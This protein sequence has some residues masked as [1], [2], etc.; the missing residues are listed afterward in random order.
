[1]DINDQLQ[2]IVASIID[3]LKGTI[4]AELRDQISDE[5]VKKLATEEF[6]ATVDAQVR[7]HIQ[8]RLDNFNFIK[9][10]DDNLQQIVANL[11]EQINRNLAEAANRQITDFITNKL[12]QFDVTAVLTAL[13]DSKVGNLLTYQH[14][15]DASIP[16]ASIDFSGFKLT[17]DQVSGG[18]ITNFGS[19]GIEDRATHVQLTLLD[20]ASAFEGPLFSPAIT[21]KGDITVDGKLIINGTV[22]A[23]ASGFADLVNKTSLATKAQLND[24]LFASFSDII[25]NKIQTDGIDLDKITQ[26]GKEIVAGNKLGY[27]ITDTNIRRLG[28]VN[29][30]QTSGENLL[31]ETLY[32]TKGRVGVNTMD[33]TAALSI[34]DQ[35]VE[36]TV[37]KHT[38]DIGYVGTP[39][40]QKLILGSN[41]K[42]NI[43]LDIDGS[44][45]IDSLR[46]GNVPMTSSVTVPNYTG[47]R[48]QL[49]WNEIP[50]P[51]A[52]IGWVCLGGTLWSGFG[53]I[54]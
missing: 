42:K 13:V 24:E 14:F 4:E 28:V 7:N 48:G 53:T 17:G 8:A 29:D 43:V 33:P 50:A 1:M 18:I 45:V 20:H 44:V 9:A 54:S 38:Q 25:F 41:S 30:L 34:W 47:D 31:S 21:V 39:R 5:V 23:T 46:I 11:S 10:S 51:G 12:K 22:D 36:V 16:H 26:G 19:V 27:H 2:P 6:E 37:S 52:P 15:P 40:S 35:E 3:N 32:V 49:V